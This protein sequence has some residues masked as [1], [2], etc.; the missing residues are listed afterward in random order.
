MS[1]EFVWIW[2]K[3]FARREKKSDESDEAGPFSTSSR[4]LTEPSVSLEL[5]AVKLGLGL[6]IA[7]REVELQE[8]DPLECIFSFPIMLVLAY[9]ACM[10]GSAH[11]AQNNAS[12]TRCTQP[13]LPH[14]ISISREIAKATIC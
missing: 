7:S 9:Y 10:L 2:L 11:Y 13:A 12:I 8:L 4:D 5:V 6:E 1:S 14:S 3:E